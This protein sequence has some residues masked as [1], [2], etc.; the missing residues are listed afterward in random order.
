MCMH[1]LTLLPPLLLAM[2]TDVSKAP[3][4]VQSSL[5]PPLPPSTP[6][7]LGSHSYYLLCWTQ[8][9]TVQST[10]KFALLVVH[11]APVTTPTQAQHTNMSPQSPVH[12]KVTTTPGHYAIGGQAD[13][14]SPWLH[15]SRAGRAADLPVEAVS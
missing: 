14:L 9:M 13:W 12:L 4:C 6:L 3:A 15:W 8:C 2:L 11:V 5:C 1:V 10:V 7:T